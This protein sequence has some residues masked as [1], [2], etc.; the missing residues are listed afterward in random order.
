M[1]IYVYLYKREVCAI[2]RIYV[3]VYK[4]QV[5]AI[6]RAYVP[7]RVRDGGNRKCCCFFA[8]AAGDVP[9]RRRWLYDPNKLKHAP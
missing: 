8:T 2:L 5:Y 7:V 1:Y 6:L 9:L 3:Y 4:H